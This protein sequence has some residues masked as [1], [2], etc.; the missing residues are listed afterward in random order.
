MLIENEMKDNDRKIVNSVN[1]M[2]GQSMRRT[3]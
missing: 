1:Y 2:N 3:L